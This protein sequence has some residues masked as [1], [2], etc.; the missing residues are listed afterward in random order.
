[1]TVD[2]LIEELKQMSPTAMVQ[3]VENF[4]ESIPRE[5]IETRYGYGIVSIVV[6]SES[7]HSTEDGPE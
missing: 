4:Y 6:E 5:I 3:V 1:M 7:D 2:E